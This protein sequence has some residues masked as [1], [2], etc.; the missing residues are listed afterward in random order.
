VS[1][2][3][4]SS[5]LFSP[6]EKQPAS[7]IDCQVLMGTVP[8]FPIENMQFNVKRLLVDGEQAEFSG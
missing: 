5:G 2:C 6:W 3:L 8:F 4:I 7:L 1:I